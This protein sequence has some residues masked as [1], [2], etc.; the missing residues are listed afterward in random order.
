MNEIM[1]S[2]AGYLLCLAL[3][4]VVFALVCSFFIKRQK[5]KQAIQEEHD[6]FRIVWADNGRRIRHCNSPGETEEAIKY[7]DDEDEVLVLRAEE[8]Y[9]YG[10]KV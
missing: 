5:V 7:F 2:S 6:Y 10:D 1:N 9:H 4:G 3:Y 8:V